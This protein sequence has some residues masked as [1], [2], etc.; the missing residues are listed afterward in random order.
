MMWGFWYLNFSFDGK[1]LAEF[2]LLP[3]IGGNK[4]RNQKNFINTGIEKEKN[5]PEFYPLEITTVNI[6][7]FI[8]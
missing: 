7:G 2:S 3:Q 5:D 6:L 1:S 4:F 8:F